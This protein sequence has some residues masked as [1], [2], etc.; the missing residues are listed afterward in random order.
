MLLQK[1]YYKIV[2]LNAVIRGNGKEPSGCEWVGVP[3]QAIG[4]PEPP[5]ANSLEL[6]FG[7]RPQTAKRSF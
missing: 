3:W 1:M 4:T 2:E 6:S 7:K 5:F